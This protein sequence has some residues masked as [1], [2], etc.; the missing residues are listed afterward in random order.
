MRTYKTIISST[1]PTQGDVLWAK[2]NNDNFALY[3]LDGGKWKP[4]E[5]EGGGDCSGGIKVFKVVYD[6]KRG[7]I[8][9]LFLSEDDNVVYTAAHFGAEVSEEVK[10]E[11]L[12]VIEANKTFANSV[13]E[14]INNGEPVCINI[15]CTD[16]SDNPYIE[17]RPCFVRYEYNG[18]NNVTTIDLTVFSAISIAIPATISYDNDKKYVLTDYVAYVGEK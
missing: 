17:Q 1:E 12:E 14:A 8:T 10:Q 11:V 6:K 18:T 2:P 3:L 5:S 16:G 7:F 4:I 9:S 15:L 13:L